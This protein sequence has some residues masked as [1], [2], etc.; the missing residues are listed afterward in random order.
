MPAQKATRSRAQ[1]YLAGISTGSARMLIQ[2]LVGVFL[3]PFILKFLDR[4][5]YAIFGLTLE[6]L[7]WLTLLDIGVAAGLK[8]Q[9]ARLSGKPDPD[10]FNRMV[11]TAFFSQNAIVLVMLVVG[12]GMAMAFP[13]FFPIRENLRHDAILLMV[14][15][16]LGGALSIGSQTFSAIL[17]ANQ[18]MHVD[19]LLSLLLIIIRT[20]LIVVLL[21]LGCGIYSLAIAHFVS[22]AVTA[23]MMVVR[24]YR[25]LPYLQ[26]RYRFA[27]WET[28][29]QIGGVGIYFSLG[30]LA[31]V[32]IHS[33]DSTVAARVV[34]VDSVT[35]FLLTGKFYELSG[36][37][38]WLI[39]ENAR[40]ILGQ[41][42]GQNKMKESLATYRQLFALSTGLAVV[43]AFS[44]WSGNKSFV[45]RWV[46][47]VNYAGRFVDLA[48][49]LS[50]I[51]GLWSMP[52]RAILSA[53]LAVRA[54]CIV[55]LIEGAL[56]LG[57][58]IILGK[59]YGLAGIVGATVIASLVTS[60]WLLPLF[61]ARMFNRPFI[62]FIWDDA[63]RV[64]LLMLCLFPIAL[65][66]RGVSTDLTGY[67]GA[68]IGAALT[69]ACGLGLIWFL[70]LDRSI[71]SRFP[72][73]Q[74]YEKLIARTVRALTG[75][76]AR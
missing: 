31:G 7:T 16:V 23:V 10:R 1:A 3:T 76:P 19:N 5:Q 70:M 47:E 29:R 69:G 52:N 33:L 72:I 40:P 63:A 45:A 54:Q 60:M 34:S 51:T 12:L 17:I 2:V 35:S 74:M 66:A 37:L 43:A 71:R 22:K 59:K 67:L 14:F 11:S 20:V 44:V 15:S 56:N 25:L 61:T 55:R 26:I 68:V 50:L 4:E 27:S 75:T 39:T 48:L 36:G 38:V 8:M 18:Q 62:R 46:G 32:I 21:E 6:L 65:A 73:R 24:T 57:L 53:N 13:H 9:A 30:G 49:A 28:F 58:S 42:L 41:M 64:F